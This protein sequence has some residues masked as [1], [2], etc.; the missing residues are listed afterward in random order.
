MDIESRDRGESQAER[1][2]EGKQRVV[3]GREEERERV[4]W[5]VFESAHCLILLNANAF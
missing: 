3:R 4:G 5:L 1:L 2:E